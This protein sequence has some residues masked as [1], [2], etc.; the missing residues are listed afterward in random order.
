MGSGACKADDL[1]LTINGNRK[2]N[3]QQEIQ[4]L[5]GRVRYGIRCGI[6][7]SG[8]RNCKTKREPNTERS[9]WS[10]PGQNAVE[11]LSSP[12]PKCSEKP[13]SNRKSH[14]LLHPRHSHAPGQNWTLTFHFLFSH[15]TKLGNSIDSQPELPVERD[16]SHYLWTFGKLF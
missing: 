9:L 4:G 13:S 3:P 16:C 11:F 14:Q 5:E 7:G 2:D 1:P 15:G 10:L 6:S 8:T 12:L